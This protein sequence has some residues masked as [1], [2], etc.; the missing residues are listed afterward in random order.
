VNLVDD[1]IAPKSRHSLK[2]LK[3]DRTWL[4]P[5][6]G[7]KRYL[8]NHQKCSKITQQHYQKERGET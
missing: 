5:V 8:G 7:L 6:C 1:E 2:P 4:C 3:P